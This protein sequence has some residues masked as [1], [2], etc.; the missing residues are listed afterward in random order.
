MGDDRTTWTNIN[1]Q[2]YFPQALSGALKDT[3]VVSYSYGSLLSGG[4]KI[5]DIAAQLSSLISELLKVHPYQTLRFVAHSMGGIIVRE[6]I[7]NYSQRDHPQLAITNV[8]CLG[9]PNNGSE[10]ATL[11][12]FF[13]WHRQIEELRHVDNGSKY[14]FDLNERWNREFK[15]EGHPRHLLLHA[16]Y[17]EQGIA[18]LGKVVKLSSAI[19]YADEYKG[20]QKTHTSIAKPDGISDSIFKWVKDSLAESLQERAKQ[21]LA[22]LIKLG[23]LKP[24]EA[25]ERLPRTVKLLEQLQD[26][27][28]TDLKRV[29]KFI[30]RGNI[31]KA[32]AIL[33]DSEPQ[34]EEVIE[35]IA[36]RRFIK[37]QLYELKFDR[38]QAS[39]YYQQAIQLT[40]QNAVYRRA[41]GIFLIQDRPKDAI[42]ELEAAQTL[43]HVEGRFLMEAYVLGE[44]GVAYEHLNDYSK[45]IDLEQRALTIE[46][47][48]G[49][50]AG[51]LAD[52]GNLGNVHIRMG[53]VT[54][55]IEFLEQAQN[56]ER[57]I[58]DIRNEATT[59][60]SL[61][62]AYRTMGA[63][64]RASQYYAEALDRLQRLQDL[65]REQA[66]WLSM[67]EM[68]VDAEMFAPAIQH[69]EKALAITRKVKDGAMEAH[70]LTNLGF[71]HLSLGQ[72]KK[73]MDY[74][75]EALRR[76]R[77]LRNATGEAIVLN[78]MGSIYQMNGDF[79]KALEFMEKAVKIQHGTD[80]VEAEANT[81]ANMAETYLRM[82]PDHSDKAIQYFTEAL[83]KYQSIPN[84]TRE[85]QVLSKLGLIYLHKAMSLKA[86]DAYTQTFDI[87]KKTEDRISQGRA[88]AGIAAGYTQL[89]NMSSE[90]VRAEAYERAIEAYRHAVDLFR[91]IGD[92]SL[93]AEML[94]NWGV[95]CR[96]LERY[97]EA[98]DL[99]QQVRTLHRNNNNPAGEAAALAS[100]G[101]GYYKLGNKEAAIEHLEL[102]R[103][104]FQ[105]QLKT[106]FPDEPLLSTLKSSP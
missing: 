43:F 5:T 93:E 35:K 33:S 95:I 99:F 25:V 55:G 13:P 14:L 66:V 70:A 15:A 81:L 38:S 18:F 47:S 67:S 64:D 50:R 88:L 19:V 20:F 71:A 101:N 8:V 12:Q 97:G 76:H 102:A 75:T 89:G 49:D 90:E 29:L 69:L 86:V 28:T 72:S 23:V 10:L 1:T 6:Y 42:R 36:Y 92:Q 41:Y 16:G 17:E 106:T 45:A 24:Q 74:Y 85:L 37:A 54:A 104:I 77:N 7:L 39:N 34:E 80:E 105:D 48:N 79:S 73:A 44:M 68:Y 63:I 103:G 53:N 30:K 9:T 11:G 61:G 83:S 2:F 46:R 40:P 87:V 82:G 62:Y 4:P 96:E 3:F 31:E 78:S 98:I 91:K 57:A 59:L 22:G 65:R 51:E 60:T 21:Y 27:S 26:L 100:M 32:L 56:L 94:N 52:L 58:G 84:R